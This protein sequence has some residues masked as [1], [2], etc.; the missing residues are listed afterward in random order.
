MDILKVLAT[1][2]NHVNYLQWVCDLHLIELLRDADIR[3]TTPLLAGQYGDAFNTVW[4]DN[5]PLVKFFYRTHQRSLSAFIHMK[6][7]KAV[8]RL[9]DNIDSLKSNISFK[10]VCL[11]PAVAQSI[12][13]VIEALENKGNQLDFKRQLTTNLDDLLAGK[14]IIRTSILDQIAVLETIVR[15]AFE[16]D[17]YRPWTENEYRHNKVVDGDATFVCF[18]RLANALM[19]VI[20]SIH[21]K[22]IYINYKEI[23]YVLSILYRLRTPKDDW[24]HRS[25]TLDTIYELTTPSIASLM[26]DYQIVRPFSSLTP[27]EA[28][29]D[30]GHLEID[31]KAYE[32]SHRGKIKNELV[33]HYL[34]LRRLLNARNACTDS[35]E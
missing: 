6:L 4:K 14:P 2:G 3:H 10:S 25:G 34:I 13:D 32:H 17:N 30:C 8:N 35:V 1:T 28:I 12:N 9:I 19:T 21:D 24:L 31:P 22:D 15:S 26:K 33:E 29:C 18:D 7:D 27:E 20:N 16:Q 23:S 5:V 11:D